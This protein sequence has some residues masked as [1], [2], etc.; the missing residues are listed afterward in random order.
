MLGGWVREPCLP[1]AFPSHCAAVLHSLCRQT[2]EICKWA[3]SL[4][5]EWDE[6]KAGETE[7]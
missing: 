6:E 4:E 2:L 1:F 5:A 3:L 7:G